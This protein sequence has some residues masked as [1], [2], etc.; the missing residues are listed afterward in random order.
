MSGRNAMRVLVGYSPDDRGEDALA[1]AA[2][3]AEA[4]G[5]SLTAAHVYP[6][7]WPAHGPGRVD[8]EWVAYL[9]SQADEA[10]AQAA[11][12]LRELSVPQ[13]RLT[14]RA[15]PHRGSGRGLAEVA[16]EVG[17]GLIV[18]GSAPR[19]RRGRIAIGSTADQLLHG[20]PAPV[21]LAPRGY[22]GNAPGKLERL[23]IAYWR[24]RDVE[25][26]LRTAAEFAGVLGLP[27]RLLT[28]VLRPPGL[29]ARFQAAGG[30]LERQ[31]AQA[32]EDL[33]EAAGFLGGGAPVERL[34][35]VGTGIDKA[36]GTVDMLPGEVLACHSS[37]DAPLRKVF[38]GESSGKI[39]RAA[40]CP[41]LVLP[42]AAGKAQVR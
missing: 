11:E 9:K 4:A 14:V 27:M 22:A 10:L 29:A 34:T 3:V 1:L 15:H 17:A 33:R 24:R 16:R 5:A 12:R 30:V 23:T 20:S 19:G 26:P 36:L 40:P 32:D 35:A 25:G 28:L 8:A 13:E 38:L 2:L 31:A 42:R 21:M 6:P 7:P 37:H 41:V 18:I 39:V